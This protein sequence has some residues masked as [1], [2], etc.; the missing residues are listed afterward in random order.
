MGVFDSNSRREVFINGVSEDVDTTSISA[1]T[2][3]DYTGIGYLDWST[4][5]I[6]F[7]QG[8]IDDIRIYN[9]VLTQSEITILANE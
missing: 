6:Q 7:F 2:G 5:N 9:R 4:G 3:I 1:L 8:I